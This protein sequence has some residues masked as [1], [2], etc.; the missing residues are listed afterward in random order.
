[1]S[2]RAIFTF[3][4][5]VAAP[6]GFMTLAVLWPLALTSVFV[7]PL[8]EL[9]A[10]LL[11]AVVLALVGFLVA[12]VFHDRA[13]CTIC[14][15]MTFAD[16]AAAAKHHDKALR[17]RHNRWSLIPALALSHG[18]LVLAAVLDLPFIVGQLG[19]SAMFVSMSI[20][21]TAW[22]L[23]RILKPWCP[24]CRRYRRWEDDGVPEPSPDLTPSTRLSS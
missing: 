10:V 12:C 7:P 9:G 17:R 21:S 13:M 5:H 15:A 16:G 2:P 11:P 4:A 18:L 14:A 3:L 8:A 24:Y 20:E 22:N 19:V 6:R 1:M 23:H